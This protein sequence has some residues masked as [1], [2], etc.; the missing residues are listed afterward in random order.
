VEYI[1]K[2]AFL[3][4]VEGKKGKKPNIRC[5][6]RLAHPRRARAQG[7]AA[8][9]TPRPQ[10]ILRV[11][12]AFTPGARGAGC[13]RE[14]SPWNRLPMPYI[15]RGGGALSHTHTTT[16]ISHSL[17]HSSP[18]PAA[19]FRVGLWV[20]KVVEELLWRAWLLRR[21]GE[22]IKV[23][24]FIQLV[25]F[26]SYTCGLCFGLEHSHFDM[27]LMVNNSYILVMLFLTIIIMLI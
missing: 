4:S 27:I 12:A 14:Y 24:T 7:M 11:S 17:E 15:R 21:I 8:P 22:L 1:R 26:L 9:C 23:A 6:S 18:P 3:E 2:Y 13:A 20:G 25:M 5:K 19:F 10:P 16:H